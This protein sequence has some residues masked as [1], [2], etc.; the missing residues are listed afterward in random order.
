MSNQD[1]EELK[2]QD[3]IAFRL[4]SGQL[5]DVSLDKSMDTT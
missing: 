4:N 5:N 2:T 1:A 3:R